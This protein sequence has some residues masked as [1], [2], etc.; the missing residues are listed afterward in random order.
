[1]G[2]SINYNLFR[3]SLPMMEPKSYLLSFDGSFFLFLLLRG[4][5]SLS[6]SRVFTS[7]PSKTTY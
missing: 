1:V 6:A 5:L 3:A 7:V 4:R 2:F